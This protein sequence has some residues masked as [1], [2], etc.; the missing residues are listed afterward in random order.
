MD[1]LERVMYVYIDRVALTTYADES[2]KTVLYN[3]FLSQVK[4]FYIKR[5]IRKPRSHL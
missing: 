4:S 2:L 1:S 5:K 3:K